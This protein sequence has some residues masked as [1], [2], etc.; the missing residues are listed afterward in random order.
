MKKMNRIMEFFWLA[1]AIIS[2]FGAVY[3]LN[4][5]GWE[6]GWFYLLFPLTAAMMW[7]YRRMMRS[8]VERWENNDR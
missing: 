7:G 8:R 2:L 5:L 3:Y 1:V 6:E 4:E